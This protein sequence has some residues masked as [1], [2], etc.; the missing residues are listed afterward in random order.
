MTAYAWCPICR[1]EFS[2]D[3]ELPCSKLTFMV[4][5]HRRREHKDG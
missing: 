4:A 2:T 3:A 5:A 1:Q